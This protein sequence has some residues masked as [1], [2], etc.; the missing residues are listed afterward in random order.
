M[1]VVA[2]SSV[3]APLDMIKTKVQADTSV[4]ALKAM[5]TAWSGGYPQ[6]IAALAWA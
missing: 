2:S 6:S 3:R 5:R 4:T 1:S